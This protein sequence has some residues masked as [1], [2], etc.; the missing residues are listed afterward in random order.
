MSPIGFPHLESQLKMLDVNRSIS[1]ILH[2]CSTVA[3]L[4]ES[5]RALQMEG[6]AER[7]VLLL[8]DGVQKFCG[9]SGQADLLTTIKHIFSGA[10]LSVRVLS[11]E[12]GYPEP[13]SLASVSACAQLGRELH[14]TKPDL[15]V[16]IGSGSLTDLCKHAFYDNLRGRAQF[17]VIPTALTVTAFTSAFAVL[18]SSGHKRTFASQLPC[19]TFFC[20]EIFSWAPVDLQRAGVGD[21]AAGFVSYADWMLGYH[22]G[23]AENYEP[24]AVRLMTHLQRRLIPE[25][26]ASS[27]DWSSP[28]ILASLAELLAAAGIAM[29]L[30]ASSAPQSGGEHAVSHVLDLLRSF[31][32]KQK[33]LHGLQVA[34][35]TSASCGIYDW[36]LEQEFIPFNRLQEISRDQC[37]RLAEHI[38]HEAVLSADPEMFSDSDRKDAFF[39]MKREV[40]ESESAVIQGIAANKSDQWSRVRARFPDFQAQ[41]PVVR[42]E[43]QEITLG[44]REFQSLLLYWGL[45]DCPEAMWP[46]GLHSEF[47]GAIRLSIFFRERFGIGD[48]AFW[49]GEDPAIISAM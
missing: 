49:L 37:A 29:N 21:L 39:Q 42:R 44:Q 47:R 8:S 15:V 13:L 24:A 38:F 6:W 48:F 33:W 16:A 36:L 4:S 43:L 18:E 2:H 46:R 40:L 19:R 25:P 22:L 26:V 17:W 10:Q 7:K 41:W 11:P 12:N 3:A 27:V 30:A 31:H 9:L 5:L 35:A 32:S 45:P 34:L 20:D 1:P 14:S 23:L 28:A